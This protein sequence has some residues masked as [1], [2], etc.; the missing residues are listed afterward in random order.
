MK[1][2]VIIKFAKTVNR[3]SVESNLENQ[4]FSL[5]A[6]GEDLESELKISEELKITN[7]ENNNIAKALICKICQKTFPDATKLENNIVN[8]HLEKEV[9]GEQLKRPKCNFCQKSFSKKC[10]LTRHA[11][12]QTSSFESRT[13]DLPNL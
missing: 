10:G 3:N 6:F 7:I 1:Q 9:C 4:R 8:E 12:C 5:E 2:P 11:S 13:G